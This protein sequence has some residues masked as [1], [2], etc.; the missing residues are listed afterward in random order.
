MSIQR[1]RKGW[2]RY[3]SGQ[4]FFVFHRAVGVALLVCGLA[5]SDLVTADEVAIDGVTNWI[6]NPSFEAGDDG[7]P[8]DWFFSRVHEEVISRHAGDLGRNGSAGISLEGRGG[9]ALGRWLTPYSIPLEPGGRYRI[10]FWYRGHGGQVYLTGNQTEW[11]AAG[12]LSVDTARSFRTVVAKPDDCTDWQRHEAVFVAP[13][14]PAWAQLCLA[15]SGRHTCQFDDV[16]MERPGL[17][18]LAPQCPTFCP[19]GKPVTLKLWAAELV[20]RA[21]DA[22]QWKIGSG[23]TIIDA[24]LD[25][26]TATWTLVVAAD[27]S[28]DLELT[29]IPSGGRPLRLTHPSFFRVL[30]LGDQRT[31]TF[32]AITDAHFYRPG[33]NERNDLF[34]KVVS[35]INALD[36]LFVLSLGDQMEAHNG[37]RDEEKKLICQAVREQLGRLEPPVFPVAGNHEIDR[38]YEGVG[39]RWYQE[40]ELGFPRFW[41]FNVGDVRVAGLDLSSPGMAAREHG[42]SFCD[43]QQA[44]WLET[45]LAE[46]PAALTVVAGH[47]SPFGEWTR[48]ADRDRL[49]AQLLGQRVDLMLCGHTHFTDD[50]VVPNGITTPPWP[51]PTPFPSGRWPQLTD[52]TVVLTTTT[53]CAFPLGNTKTRGYRYLLVRDGRLSWQAVLP[54]SL[55]ISRQERPDGGTEFSISNGN[56]LA[57]TGL[58]L[59]ARV[60]GTATVTVNGQAAAFEAVQA[61]TD[62]CQVIVSIDVPKQAS[63]TCSIAP[64][65]AGD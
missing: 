36:P 59:V 47:I 42:G 4:R 37:K 3:L 21:A 55:A 28:A 2:R 51:R 56:E 58:P 41:S 60:P 29:A 23:L 57:I 33:R 38:G 5:L 34:G 17:R 10:S 9:L 64:A 15:V 12:R 18:L 52:Q 6:S 13:G 65:A 25:V 27:Q 44:S 49:L 8:V 24:S 14:Y 53:T 61:D 63:I 16:F 40:K 35:T 39:S 22:V 30:R 54:P 26:A 43:R 62:H 31:F 19:V 11:T 1:T 45:W 48:G 7:D 20:G 46:Q 32:A 50:R